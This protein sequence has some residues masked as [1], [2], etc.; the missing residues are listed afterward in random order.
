MLN[1]KINKD[2]D[3]NEKNTSKLKFSDHP[4]FKKINLELE[5][6]QETINLLSIKINELEDF[7]KDSQELFKTE[8]IKK[9]KLAQEEVNKT[10]MN[11][12][13]KFDIELKSAKKYAIEGQAIDLINIISQ[14]ES[15]ISIKSNDEKIQNYLNGFQMFSRMFNSLLNEMGISEISI[16]IGDEFNEKY[17][18]AI[19][20]IDDKQYQK[21]TVIN[22]IKKGYKLHDKVILHSQVT[23]VE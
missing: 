2:I 19:H 9:A 21:N 11:L 4:E 3:K 14:F 5:E 22:I 8:I 23:V 7:Q 13:T 15:V 20:A 10:A 6:A 12:K 18:E 16:K 1:K 17:M